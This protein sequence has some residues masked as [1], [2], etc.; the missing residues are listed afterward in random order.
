MPQVQNNNSDKYKNNS[1]N[2]NRNSKRLVKEFLVVVTG[3][4]K[5]FGGHMQPTGSKVETHGLDHCI[6]VLWPA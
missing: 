6:L 3:L 1:D 5:S 2:S 4:K